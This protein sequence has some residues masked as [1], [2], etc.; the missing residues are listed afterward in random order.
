MGRSL[1][2]GVV[3]F[4][5]L[6]GCG[7]PPNQEES[8]LRGAGRRLGREK[9]SV[10]VQ[11]EDCVRTQGYWKNHGG[12]PV[13]SLTLGTRVYTEAELRLIFDAPVMGNGLIQLAHQL[14]AAKLNIAAG[15]DATLIA[16][17]IADADALIGGLVVPPIGGG[18]LATSATSSLNAQLTAFNEGTIG[19]IHCG[20]TP[21]PEPRCGDGNMDAGEQCDD[22]NNVDGDG[23]S[24]NCTTE[25]PPPQPRCGDGNMDAGEQCDDGNN[26]DGD[27]CSANC[28]TETPPPQPRCGDGH[29]DAGEQCD[30]GN[31]VSGD[32]CSS[33]CMT[34]APPAPVCGNGVLEAGEECD[35]GN[36]VDDDL[37]TNACKICLKPL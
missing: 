3:A 31:L 28:T 35:D 9:A 13:S 6:T 32:G 25:T 30:D 36:T 8:A 21:P 22:G 4:L 10:S 34:E 1:L 7:Q 37:C 18:S 16:S 17:A 11:S 26:V 29:L 23:C 20:E 14:I 5:V 33:T 19:P 12:W 27:G 2:H 15:A 24:A